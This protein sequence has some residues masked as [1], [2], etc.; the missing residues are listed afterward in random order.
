MQNFNDYQF[1]C[2]KAYIENLSNEDF[3]ALYHDKRVHFDRLVMFVH[4][5]TLIRGAKAVTK[6]DKE[7]F[8]YPN[9]VVAGVFGLS[10]SSLKVYFWRQK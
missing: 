8:R 4:E 3:K 6:E 5:Q 10:V 2:E 1:E 9:K 7:F